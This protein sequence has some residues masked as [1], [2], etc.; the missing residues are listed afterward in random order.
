M[1]L[2][3]GLVFYGVDCAVLAVD[4]S[5]LRSLAPAATPPDPPAPGAALEALEPCYPEPPALF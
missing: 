1:R 5:L 3:F 4:K 2:A